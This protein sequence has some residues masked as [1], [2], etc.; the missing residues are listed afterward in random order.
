MFPDIPIAKL[1][2]LFIS[3]SAIL[4]INCIGLAIYRLYF[5]PLAKF[6]GPK[7]AA[8]TTWYEFYWDVIKDGKFTFHIHDLH[9]KYGM[10]SVHPAMK[11]H[12]AKIDNEKG[13]IIRISPSELHIHDPDY[14]DQLYARSGRRDKFS[15]IS[16]RFGYPNDIFFTT[17]HNLHKLRRKAISP[18]FSGTKISEFHPVIL[19][20]IDK[21]CRKISLHQENGSVLPLSKCWFALTTDIIT[22]YAFAK[23]Y[24][25]LDSEEFKDTETFHK[26]FLIMHTSGLVIQHFPWLYTILDSLP[27]WVIEKINPTLK[28]L[29][30][31]RLVVFLLQLLLKK[32][33]ALIDE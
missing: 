33:Q 22:Q 18:F 23:S 13:P 1:L 19:S 28:H 27:D 6:P 12:R 15:G 21:L 24:D 31:F 3:L 11:I 30:D 16:S 29:T 14:F 5:H 10:K 2:K 9:K 32:K 26:G 20:K 4:V 7:L 17:P 25:H 8:I